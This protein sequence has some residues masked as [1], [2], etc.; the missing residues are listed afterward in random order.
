MAAAEFCTGNP[1]PSRLDCCMRLPFVA[2]LL[3]APVA[4]A[5]S[6]AE[7]MANDTYSPAHDY[8]LVH[9]RIELKNFAW[10]S[11]SLDGRVTPTLVALRAVLASVNLAPCKRLP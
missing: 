6:N 10:D 1:L 7:R 8:D 3:L 2:L 4:A 9:Q 11:T 5:Q